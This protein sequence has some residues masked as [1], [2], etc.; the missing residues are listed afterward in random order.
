MIYLLGMQ[1][2]TAMSM[3]RQDRDKIKNEDLQEVTKQ[4]RVVRSEAE[5][6]DLH[7]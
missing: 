3:Q 4:K 2:H 5:G 6:E 7:P 1:V